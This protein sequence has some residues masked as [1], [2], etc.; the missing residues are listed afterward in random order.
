MS[1]QMWHPLLEGPKLGCDTDRHWGDLGGRRYMNDISMLSGRGQRRHP[2]GAVSTDVRAIC[3][4]WRT[5]SICRA[6]ILSLTKEGEAPQ[7]DEG[8]RSHVSQIPRP[9]GG[10]GRKHCQRSNAFAHHRHRAAQSSMRASGRYRILT[11]MGTMVNIITE[12]DDRH[13]IANPSAIMRLLVARG[14]R[15]FGDGFAALLL[16]AYLIAIGI[17]AG[18]VWHHD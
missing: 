10:R 11:F 16:P 3:T 1:R 4:F 6:H 2:E 5:F 13:A 14:L 12:G 17:A 7:P 18:G 15:D 9:G 8:R